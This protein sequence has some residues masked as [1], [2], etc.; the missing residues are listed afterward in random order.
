MFFSLML[1]LY[2]FSKLVSNVSFIYKLKKI[3]V[4]FKC[5]NLIL[6]NFFLP[7]STKLYYLEKG[8]K[9]KTLIKLIRN[10]YINYISWCLE[11]GFE[12]IKIS[13]N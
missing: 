9:F 8:Y 4:F 1:K 3:N 7:V 2:H 6:H 11:K 12:Q 13:K 5:L 10:N